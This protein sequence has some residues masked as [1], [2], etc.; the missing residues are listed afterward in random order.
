MKNRNNIIDFSFLLV[1]EIKPRALHVLSAH[2]QSYTLK[3]YN[4]FMSQKGYRPS[5]PNAFFLCDL[6]LL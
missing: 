4:R 2:S 1:L 3:S 6:N 5:P